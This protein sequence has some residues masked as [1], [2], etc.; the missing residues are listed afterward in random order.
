MD[1]E[2]ADTRANSLLEHDFCPI[3]PTDERTDTQTL[4]DQ[5]KFLSNERKERCAQ[6]LTKAI[7][8]TLDGH[9]SFVFHFLPISFHFNMKLAIP[10]IER[11]PT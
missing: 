11:V 6:K 2:P 5:V 8:M 1:P 4:L 3:F 10:G 7:S 9:N